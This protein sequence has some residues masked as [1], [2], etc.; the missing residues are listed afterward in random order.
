MISDLDLVLE[1]TFCCTKSTFRKSGAKV[2]Q[3]EEQR[4]CKA[5]SKGC[6]YLRKLEQIYL[7]TGGFAPLFLKVDF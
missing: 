1:A 2:V 4:L 6:N 5:K 3:S 7:I